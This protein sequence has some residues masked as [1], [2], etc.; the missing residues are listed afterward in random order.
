[1]KGN[2]VQGSA[3]GRLG[4]A[5]RRGVVH[6]T[7]QDGVT[8]RALPGPGGVLGWPRGRCRSFCS[9]SGRRSPGLRRVTESP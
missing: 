9:E 5:P 7:L 2:G 6:A 1:M 4:G 3:G 8:V